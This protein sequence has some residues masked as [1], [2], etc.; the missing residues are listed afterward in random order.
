MQRPRD[1]RYAWL[2]ISL[3]ASRVVLSMSPC[4]GI[5]DALQQSYAVSPQKDCCDLEN[6]TS[7]KGEA[8]KSLINTQSN[9]IY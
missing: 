9:R 7:S 3:R 1:S 6:C 5:L 8:C 2:F 4:I